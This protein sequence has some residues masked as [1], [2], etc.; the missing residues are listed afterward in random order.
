MH[1][2]NSYYVPFIGITIP[3]TYVSPRFARGQIKVFANSKSHFC[4]LF[5]WAPLTH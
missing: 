5:D 1:G 3:L 4:L 2:L